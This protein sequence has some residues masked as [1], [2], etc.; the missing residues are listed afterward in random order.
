MVFEVSS[1]NPKGL[2]SEAFAEVE[3]TMFTI[4]SDLQAL[5]TC[6]IFSRCGQAAL[7][8]QVTQLQGYYLF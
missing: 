6:L 7:A 3:S 4:S 8:Q 1:E 5:M 2:S